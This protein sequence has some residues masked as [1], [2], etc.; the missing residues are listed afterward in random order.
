MSLPGTEF[1]L[2]SSGRNPVMEFIDSLAAADAAALVAAIQAFAFEFPDVVTV[3]I[4]PLA[5]K[6][7][8][9]KVRRFR[10]LYGSRGRR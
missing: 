7:W 9:M 6:L 1:F 5:G 2:T 8:E 3:S 10:I 4:K